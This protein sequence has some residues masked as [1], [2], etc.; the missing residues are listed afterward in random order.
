MI[1]SFTYEVAFKTILKDILLFYIFREN[2]KTRTKV[3]HMSK[4]VS[5]LEDLKVLLKNYA[6][7]P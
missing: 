5:R 2:L 6:A 7:S 4:V 3:V 1:A